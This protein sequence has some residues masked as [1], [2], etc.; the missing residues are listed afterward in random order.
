MFIE[1]VMLDCSSSDTLVCPKKY[2]R[3]SKTSYF[4][5]F[6]SGSSSNGS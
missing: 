3:Y 4:T 5:F 6:A 1:A 2:Q